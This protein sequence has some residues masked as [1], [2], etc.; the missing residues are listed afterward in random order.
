MSTSQRV[1]HGFHRLAIFLTAIALVIGTILSVGIAVEQANRAKA[2]HDEQVSL[3]CAQTALHD[4]SVKSKY[5]DAPKGYFADDERI[6]LAQLGCSTISWTPTVREISAAKP[7]SNFSYIA[8]SLPGL[9][10][11][12]AITLAIS[13]LVYAAVRAIGWVIGGFAAS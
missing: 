7:P 6:D 2:S 5:A 11:C 4:G 1:S 12:L 9:G 10:I 3:V 13:L 8:N